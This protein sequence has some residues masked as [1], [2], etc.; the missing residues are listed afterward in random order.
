MIN[1][2]RTVEPWLH[3]GDVL[4]DRDKMRKV[5]LAMGCLPMLAGFC[6]VPPAHAQ[7]GAEL[8]RLINGYRSAPQ[9]C[10]GRAAGPVAQLVPEPALTRVRIVTGT[11]LEQ[12][13]EDIGYP[14]ERAQAISVSGPPDAQAALAAMLPLYCSVL[15][16]TQFSAI[17][18]LRTGN[19]WQVILARPFVAPKL[20]DWAET[21]RTIL[22]ASNAARAAGHICGERFFPPAPPLAW[23]QSLGQAA[24]VHSEDMAANRY[25]SHQGTDNTVV[26]DRARQAG[27]AWRRIGENIAAGLG[28]PEEA[29]AGWLSSP[30]HCANLMEAGFTE[31]GAAYA[32]N[33]KS[34]T[35]RT[36]WTQVF[37][38]T[39]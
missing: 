9:D 30:P 22:D 11:F 29:V 14:V 17:G 18:T 1:C 5:K 39:R 32:I 28:T 12:K 16:N 20:P 26:G 8:A 21:G 3:G 36:Y 7:G 31:M 38:S 35:Q 24:L 6:G 23:N 34:K 15:L 37:G 2:H 33:P 13:L 10:Q 25:F 4:P 19:Q 27:Y